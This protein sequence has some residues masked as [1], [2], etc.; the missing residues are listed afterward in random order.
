[1]RNISDKLVETNKTH[2][3]CSV[4][5]FENH[6]LYAIMGENIVDSERPQMT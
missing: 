6:A 4:T 3:L 1:M 2:I 5:F